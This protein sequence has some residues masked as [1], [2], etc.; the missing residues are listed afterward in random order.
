MKPFSLPF[1]LSCDFWNALVTAKMISGCVVWWGGGGGEGG[2]GEG[3]RSSEDYAIDEIL[4]IQDAE[5]CLNPSESC[6]SESYK[7]RNSSN[8]VK[9]II[10]SV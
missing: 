5:N 2:K 8:E 7:K 3:N 6:L 4:I 1:E 10:C 9:Y